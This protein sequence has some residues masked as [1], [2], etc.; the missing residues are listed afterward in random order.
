MINALYYNDPIRLGFSKGFKMRMS[1]VVY[2]GVIET[3]RKTKVPAH[4]D[5]SH[6]LHSEYLARLTAIVG[7]TIST[8]SWSEPLFGKV[9]PRYTNLLAP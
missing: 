6:F 1:R 8:E 4:E 7:L 5:V 9:D 3:D 2:S